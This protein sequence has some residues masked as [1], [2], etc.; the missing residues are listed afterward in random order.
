[1][2][3]L[4]KY[5]EDFKEYDAM[6]KDFIDDEL[7][8][9]QLKKWE[10]PSK[11]DVRRVLEKASHLIR[12]EPEEMAVLLQNQDPDLT[13]EM[14]DLAHKLKREVYGE[15]I[16]F[17]APLYISDKCANNCV[18]CGYRSSNEA[19]HRKTLTMEELRREVEIMIREGQ[20]RT[21]LV[22]GESPETNAD[23][24]CETV[25]QVYSVKSEHGEIRRANINCAPLTRDELRKLKQVGIGTFQVFQ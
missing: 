15:R 22:Y 3:F 9:Q 21:V 6:E 13:A 25:R 12:L 20:K 2:N 11:A 4:E 1:M 5:R 18:Y 19:M 10:N 17:F 23:Y 16:V 7:I 8:W 14:Y 24:I